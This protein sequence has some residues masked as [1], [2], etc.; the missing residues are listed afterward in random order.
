MNHL[1]KFKLRAQTLP[2]ATPPLGKIPP[3]TKITLVRL[4]V[5]GLQD[6]LFCP[7]STF[8][9]QAYPEVHIDSE[10]TFL[11]KYYIITV[12]IFF[13]PFHQYLKKF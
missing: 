7:D 5:L 13:E 12:L 2:D 8:S 3:F 4:N 11:K 10:S 1:C 9:F 6:P